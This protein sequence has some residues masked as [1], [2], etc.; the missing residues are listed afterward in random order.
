MS[1]LGKMVEVLSFVSWRNISPCKSTVQ[2][3]TSFF[4]TLSA[5]SRFSAEIKVF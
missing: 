5:P 1:L 2:Q 4:L 3:I